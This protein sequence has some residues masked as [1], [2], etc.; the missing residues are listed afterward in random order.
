MNADR[1]REGTDAFASGWSFARF[2]RG[3]DREPR[4]CLDHVRG[5]VPSAAEQ[6]GRLDGIGVRVRRQK[7]E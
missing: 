4:V 1:S 3:T 6:E 2:D 7:R 5:A